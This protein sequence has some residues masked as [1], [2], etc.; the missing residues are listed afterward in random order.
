MDREIFDRAPFAAWIHNLSKNQMKYLN[1]KLAD[2]NM[3]HDLRFII[4]I[5]DHPGSSQDD[6]VNFSGQSKGNIAKIVRKLEDEGFIIREINP[7][8]RRKY[9]LKTTQKANDLVPKVR[10]ISKDWEREVGLTDD[11]EEL[12]QRIKE[13]SIN[14]MKIIEE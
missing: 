7:E 11:D 4:F 10:Q 14:S 8:N 9:M 6:L 12:K 3:D 2:L 13:I 5:Y 1:S